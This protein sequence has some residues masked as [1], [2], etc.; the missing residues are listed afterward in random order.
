MLDLFPLPTL[1]VM[2]RGSGR[3]APEQG[4]PQLRL[5]P[6]L[7]LDQLVAQVFK[8]IVELSRVFIRVDVRLHEPLPRDL[9]IDLI[10][11]KDGLLDLLL[12]NSVIG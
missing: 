2:E 9:L 10:F 6:P 11:V 7:W 5:G 12:V 8:L 3:T 1:L 4:Y